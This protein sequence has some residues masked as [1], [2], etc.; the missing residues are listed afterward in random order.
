MLSY[1]VVETVFKGF[2]NS[3]WISLW[4]W[5]EP[6]QIPARSRGH[7]CSQN[8]LASQ[9]QC[10]QLFLR[11]L[12]EIRQLVQLAH[13]ANVHWRWWTEQCSEKCINQAHLLFSCCSLKDHSSIIRTDSDAEAPQAV[14]AHNPQFRMVIATLCYSMISLARWKNLLST[15]RC[16]GIVIFS[17]FPPTVQ[18]KV[19]AAAIMISTFCCFWDV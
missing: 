19:T 14:E 10:W 3:L 11:H 13:G 8:V 15:S 12:V 5:W 1:S 6:L 9:S 17:S 2:L 4:C 7:F 16:E 18:N